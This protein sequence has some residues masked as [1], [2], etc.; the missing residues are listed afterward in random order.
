MS[1][2][3][4]CGRELCVL[5]CKAHTEA[6]VPP[7]QKLI[8]DWAV[9]AILSHE[10]CAMNWHVKMNTTKSMRWAVGFRSEPT[11]CETVSLVKIATTGVP[12]GVKLWKLALPWLPEQTVWDWCLLRPAVYQRRSSTILNCCLTYLVPLYASSSSKDPFSCV[13]LTNSMPSWSRIWDVWY[14]I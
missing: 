11:T 1:W 12:G 10:P 14:S 7:L 4:D 8:S 13:N 3:N 2:Q 9:T 6:V 5:W